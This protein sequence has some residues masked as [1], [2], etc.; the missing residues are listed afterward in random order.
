MKKIPFQSEWLQNLLPDGLMYPSVTI[1]SGPGGSGK[2]LVGYLFASEWLKQGGSVFFLLT[3]TTLEYFHETMHLLGVDPGQYKKNIYYV[4]LDLSR[5]EITQTS[6][7]YWKANFV[8]PWVWDLVFDRI[9]NVSDKNRANPGTM[10]SGPAL[11]LLFFSETYK[12]QLQQHILD[13]LKKDKQ[14]SYFLSLNSDA[15]T[16]L[17]VPLE[18][19]ADNL[20][21]SHMEKPMQLFLKIT[22]MKDVRFNQNNVMVPLSDEIL[23]S[24]RKEA[25][26]GKRKLIPAIKKL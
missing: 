7:H 9:N 14:N 22:R 3:N 24:L 2:P 21:I 6:S 18:E 15:F 11:N 20:M 13:C 4:E 16:E 1:V 17:V 8:K 5:S 25:E 12:I 10:I 23:A 19:A 26:K